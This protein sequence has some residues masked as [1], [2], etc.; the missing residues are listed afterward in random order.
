MEASGLKQN[1]SRLLGGSR[2][3][4]EGPGGSRRLQEVPRGSRRGSG[5]A[6]GHYKR[7][8]E[9]PGGSRRLLDNCELVGAL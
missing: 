7:F 4:Q 2:T 1:V 5:E 8:Q 9:A 3:L 6:A